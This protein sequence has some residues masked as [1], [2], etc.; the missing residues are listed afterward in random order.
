M[1]LEKGFEKRIATL[2]Q[3]HPQKHIQD[4]FLHIC[5]KV[6]LQKQNFRDTRGIIYCT[7]KGE[8]RH[9]MSTALAA[10]L[11]LKY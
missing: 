1:R 10:N 11:E 3:S 6:S 5:L 2:K 4:P 7:S 8:G 9:N